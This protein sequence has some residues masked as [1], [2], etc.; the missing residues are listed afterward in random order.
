ME[1]KIDYFSG[2]GNLFSVLD[3]RNNI[4]TDEFLA[5]L[6]KKSCKRENPFTIDTEGFIVLSNPVI[7]DVENSFLVKFFNPDGSSGMM[8]GNGARCAVKFA[9]MLNLINKN[10]IKKPVRFELAGTEYFA[11][12]NNDL[13]SVRFPRPKNYKP[14][15]KIPFQEYVILGDFVDVGTPHLLFK[16]EEIPNSKKF[17]FRFY[18]IDD[19][20]MPI[21]YNELKFPDGVNVSI[22]VIENRSRVHI[23]TY[24]RGVEHETGACGTG[25]ISLAYT[26]Y[27]KGLVNSHVEIIPTS[28]NSLFVET[29]IDEDNEVI[30]FNLTG[31]AE[32]IGEALIQF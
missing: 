14:N 28:K 20:A 25:A 17:I 2:A 31:N 23:R 1:I 26:L 19:F 4:I 8:C 13:I 3:N 15:L 12:I 6:A 24:E 7:A 11:Y 32:K 29:I 5:D 9:E 27:K 10:E 16:Y 21:R 22:Y 30:G 18:P